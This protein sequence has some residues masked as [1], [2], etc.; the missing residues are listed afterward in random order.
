M[1]GR[2]NKM[3]FKCLFNFSEHISANTPNFNAYINIYIYINLDFN[4]T[5]I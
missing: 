4:F 2:V 1:P 3:C 5:K